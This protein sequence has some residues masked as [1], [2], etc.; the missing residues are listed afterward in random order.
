[1]KEHIDWCIYELLHG[2]GCIVVE[3]ID[4]ITEMEICY[5]GKD[6]RGMLRFSIQGWGYEYSWKDE[7]YLA[8][9]VSILEN[10]KE[11]I[12]WG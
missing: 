2:E 12:N 10:D 11:L 3:H 8:D 5:I 9:V 7:C 1:M 4:G 6:D